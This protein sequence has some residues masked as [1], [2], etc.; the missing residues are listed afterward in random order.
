VALDTP[1]SRAAP[2]RPGHT[3]TGAGLGCKVAASTVW[4]IFKTAGIDPTPSRS[5]QTWRAFLQAQATTIL[6]MDHFHVD[7]VFL[8]RYVLF[9]IEHR[10]RRVHLAGI[11]AP[12]TGE[13]VTQQ[14]RNLLKG[15]AGSF[16]FVIRDRDT[17][18]TGALDA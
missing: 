17:K 7:T 9:F 18:F 11:T 14:A 12:P 10:T 16:R 5:G 4:E 8:R 6:A 3:V 2:D 13:W 15:R 1:F